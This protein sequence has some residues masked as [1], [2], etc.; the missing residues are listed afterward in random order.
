VRYDPALAKKLLAE[1]GYEKGLVIKGIVENDTESQT[2]VEAIKSMLA[3][4]G[5]ELQTESLDPVAVA[6][7]VVNLEFDLCAWNYKYVFDPDSIATTF[8]HPDMNQR[9]NY[10]KKAVELIVAGREEVHFERRKEIYYKLEKVVYD[11][12]MDVWL[13]WEMEALA[14]RKRVQGFNLDMHAKGFVGYHESHPLWFK[15][16]DM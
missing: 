13:W 5:I 4:V 2:R 12:F 7:R 10:N 15:D 8:Y 3:N 6:D 16:G 9:R 11:N 1:A 14:F